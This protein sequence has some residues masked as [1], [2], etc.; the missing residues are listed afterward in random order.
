[1]SLNALKLS[2]S[3]EMFLKVRRVG[4]AALSDVR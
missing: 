4:G 3:L 2:K 1:M